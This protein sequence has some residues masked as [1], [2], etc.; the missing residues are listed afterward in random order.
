MVR[1]DQQWSKQKLIE[2]VT[3]SSWLAH[4]V[5]DETNRTEPENKK[6]GGWRGPDIFNS[7]KRLIKGDIVIIS[8]EK[9]G[10][11]PHHEPLSP[12]SASLK[13]IHG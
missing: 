8:F 1:R 9:L 3:P 5:T 2:N 10:L 4:I 7:T 12:L 13:H 11:R 6:R